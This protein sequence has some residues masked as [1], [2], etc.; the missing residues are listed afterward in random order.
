M[1]TVQHRCRVVVRPPLV[2]VDL[3]LR[4]AVGRDHVYTARREGTGSRPARAHEPD[5]KRAI[6]Q[7][8]QRKPGEAAVEERE[9]G[10]AEDAGHDPEAHHDPRLRPRLHLEVVVNRRHQEHAL[11]GST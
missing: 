5:D 11:G 3:Q 1:D 8:G 10:G 7:P 6:R 4:V 2:P 9:A